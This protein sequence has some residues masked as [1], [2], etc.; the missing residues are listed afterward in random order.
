MM[1]GLRDGP[2]LRHRPLPIALLQSPLRIRRMLSNSVFLSV[3][4]STI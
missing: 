3:N 2:I 1:C 4:W